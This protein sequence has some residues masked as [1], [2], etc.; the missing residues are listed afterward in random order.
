MYVTKARRLGS[1]LGLVARF[2]STE[3]RPAGDIPGEPVHLQGLAATSVQY[4]HYVSTYF[5]LDT[6]PSSVAILKTWA[7]TKCINTTPE[8]R[9]RRLIIF[10]LY[11]SQAQRCSN[12]LP[13]T[14]LSLSFQ[15]AII[16]TYCSAPSFHPIHTLTKSFDSPTA[17]TFE[18]VSPSPQPTTPHKRQEISKYSVPSSSAT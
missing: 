8:D 16:T 3:P 13:T 12:P 15:I 1:R 14:S 6:A 17:E 9:R 18:T 7:I 5:S 10:F 4:T 2:T 11:S